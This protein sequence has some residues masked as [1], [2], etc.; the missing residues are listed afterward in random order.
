[1]KFHLIY[2]YEET[3]TSTGRRGQHSCCGFY[4]PVATCRSK[5]CFALLQVCLFG[6]AEVS[7]RDALRSK[8]S[9]EELLGV[10]EAAVKRKKPKHAGKF[11][12]ITTDKHAGK[13]S[14]IT[15]DKHAGKFSLITTDKHAGKFSLIMVSSL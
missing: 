8:A 7:L 4:I 11:S 15:T 14:L 10:I 12:L 1:M 9:D 13:F 2:M 3:C 5:W 6:N